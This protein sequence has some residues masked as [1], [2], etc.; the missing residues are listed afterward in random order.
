MGYAAFEN[1]NQFRLM[2]ELALLL[3]KY[4]AKSTDQDSVKEGRRAAMDFQ[5]KRV[6]QFILC[7]RVACTW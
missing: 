4:G 3:A 7:R 1:L 2:D 5:S 6:L